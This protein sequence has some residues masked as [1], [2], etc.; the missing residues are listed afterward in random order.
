MD[1]GSWVS[2]SSRFD[3]ITRHPRQIYIRTL[4]PSTTLQSSISAVIFSYNHNQSLHQLPSWWNFSSQPSWSLFPWHFLRKRRQMKQ[5][6]IVH[7]SAPWYMTQD[8][9]KM[10][11]GGSSCSRIS[12]TWKW[13]ITATTVD[14]KRCP[15]QNAG[16]DILFYYWY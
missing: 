12:V 15:S 4:A 8:V 5:L 16:Y 6:Q 7:L 1:S 13:Q 3:Y 9:E 10:H 11:K 14:I 2:K